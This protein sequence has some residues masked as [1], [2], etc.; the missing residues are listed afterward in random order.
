[1]LAA[2]FV[3]LPS[4]LVSDGLLFAG[5]SHARTTVPLLPHAGATSE[6]GF[7]ALIRNGKIFI[8]VVG[9][10]GF[11]VRTPLDRKSGKPWSISATGSLVKV[12]LPGSEEPVKLQIVPGSLTK[13][14]RTMPYGKCEV[15]TLDARS[16]H[17]DLAARLEFIV[18]EAFDNVIL[19][20]VTLVNEGKA[21]IDV[22]SYS[23]LAGLM[24]AVNSGADSSFRFWS[25]QGGSYPER[26]DWMFPLEKGYARSNYQGM[27]APDYG[28]GM[29]VVDFWTK[30]RGLA[31]AVT[32]EK[33]LFVSLPVIV[34]DSGLVSMSVQDTGRITIS[35]HGSALLPQCALIAHEGD[36]YN[37]LNTYSRL[38]QAAGTSFARPPADAYEPEW[39]AWGYGREFSATQILRTLPVAKSLGFGWVTIDDG[40]QDN[41][42]DWEPSATR[43]PG[44]EREFEA[45]VD[46]IHS[47]GMKVR[48]WWSPLAAHDSSYSASCFPDRMHEFGMSVQS[49]LAS[50]HPDWFLLDGNGKRIQISWWNAY[51]LCPA[52]PQ[53]SEYFREFVRKAVLRWKIDGF[54]LDGQHLNQVPWCYNPGHH[55][56][57]PSESAECVP[58]F[59]KT[60]YSTATRLN[61]DFLIQLCPCGTNFSFYN[62]PWVSQTVASDP[63]SSWQVRLKGKTFQAL[64][65]G[66]AVFSGDHVELTNRTWDP[67]SQ[68]FIPRGEEDFASTLAVGGIPASKFT[69]GGIRQEDSSLTLS[70]GKLDEY[71][72]WLNLYNAE[73]MSEGEYLN[74]YDIA[75]DKPEAH[76]IRK[77]DVYY[78]SFFSAEH[79]RGN[80]ELRGL[81]QGRYTVTDIVRGKDIALVRSESPYIELE[82][83]RSVIVK[84][85]RQK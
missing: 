77:G 58:E 3:Q 73:K 27:N 44:G 64:Y 62:L 34:T 75:F 55:H 50:L 36:F 11:Q 42:G 10:A 85:V 78:Y 33:P 41:L 68:K 81:K 76:V 46:S 16:G 4:G 30:Q 35:P 6:S 23:L 24:D 37:A 26:P 63:L 57:S 74:L 84:A 22:R 43:F 82:F 69:V 52:E 17:P 29:P 2:L 72:K 19:V 21:P 14:I 32:S 38:M 66:R 54:K 45:F 20:N 18:P 65:G 51:T 59:F 13:R 79:F 83:D 15:A 47:Y 9:N 56:K 49:K 61:P 60:I 40:W 25:F 80:V 48:L 12:T 67:A 39:C 1:M 70:G 71:R 31:L 7:S 8:A 28:G 5:T 53:V